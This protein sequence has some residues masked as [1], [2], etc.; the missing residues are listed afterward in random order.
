MGQFEIGLDK[1]QDQRI[2]HPNIMNLESLLQIAN[3][4]FPGRKFKNLDEICFD[5]DACN[6]FC[7]NKDSV[8]F[9]MFH[10]VLRKRK[11]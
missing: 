11:M 4:K 6:V 10:H 2:N 7:S 5:R 1:N 3:L 9:A 8:F